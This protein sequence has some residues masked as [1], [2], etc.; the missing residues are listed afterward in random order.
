MR[1]I[2]LTF[3]SNLGMGS[4]LLEIMRV[5]LVDTRIF[6]GNISARAYTSADNADEVILFEEWDNATS[7]LEYLKWRRDDGLSELLKLILAGPI[8][9]LGLVSHF[10]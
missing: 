10:A 1:T 3:M 6:K 2:I 9:R 5:G 7:N 4:Q 8:N